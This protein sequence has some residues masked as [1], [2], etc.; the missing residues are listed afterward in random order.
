MYLRH[1]TSVPMS[2]CIPK[3][4]AIDFIDIRLI[5]SRISRLMIKDVKSEMAQR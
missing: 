3:A 4:D 2:I 5:Y 1:F